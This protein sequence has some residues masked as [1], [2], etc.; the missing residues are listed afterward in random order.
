MTVQTAYNLIRYIC[1]KSQGTY[2]SPSDFNLIIN[3]ASI[4]HVNFLI[5]EFQ[6]YLPQRSEPRVMYSQNRNVR[7]RLTPFIYGKQL[8]VGGDGLAPYPDDYIQTD[9]MWSIYGN[10]KVRYAPQNKLDSMVNSTIDPVATKPVFAIEDNGFRFYPN[11]IGAAKL[12]YVRMPRQI[13]WANVYANVYGQNNRPTY[14]PA[15]S[16]DPE[17]D[18]VEMMEIIGKALRMVGVNLQANEI[19]QYA[20]E[21]KIQGQ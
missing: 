10:R 19:S 6:T 15:N 7:Q 5:G 8:S 14:D 21:I 2:I 13:V 1:N 12:S 16:V 11:D 4:G 17:W 18:D 9:A 3:Q 20:Q